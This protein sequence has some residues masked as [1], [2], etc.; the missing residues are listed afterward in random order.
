MT[1]S[2][3]FDELV[4]RSISAGLLL[5]NVLSKYD[6]KRFA[7]SLLVTMGVEFMS[8]KVGIAKFLVLR[9]E[10]TYLNFD[11]VLRIIR[12]SLFFKNFLIWE[13]IISLQWSNFLRILSWCT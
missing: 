13:S 6:A 9:K 4:G 2:M 7:L 5:E 1:N 12:F 8:N 11:L 3:L 10:L